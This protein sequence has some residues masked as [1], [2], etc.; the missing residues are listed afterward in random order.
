MTTRRKLQYLAA[1]V[2]AI[3]AVTIFGFV[4]KA[5]TI[6]EETMD[7]IT[8]PSNNTMLILLIL[9]VAVG[10]GLFFHLWSRLRSIEAQE[11]ESEKG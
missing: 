7:L 3:V 6:W 2:I 4:W 10:A 1:A 9:I 11:L 5:F 8:S